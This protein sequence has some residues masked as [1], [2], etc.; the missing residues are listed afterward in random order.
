[1]TNRSADEFGPVM[2][3]LTVEDGQ[4]SDQ[5]VLDQSVAQLVIAE[6]EMTGRRRLVIA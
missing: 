6:A 1:M 5:A 4:A 2:P 3:Y